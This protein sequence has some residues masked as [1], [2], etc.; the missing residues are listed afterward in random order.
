MIS[1]EYFRRKSHCTLQHRN[2]G[3]AVI[4]NQHRPVT[5]LHDQIFSEICLHLQKFS[6]LT[7][8]DIRT[9][10]Y[11]MADSTF[12]PKLERCT[13]LVSLSIPDPKWLPSLTALINLTSLTLSFNVELQFLDSLLVLH[14]LTSLKIG[15]NEPR[16]NTL[17]GSPI[18]QLTQL[19]TLS[20]IPSP[21]ISYTQLT[22]LRT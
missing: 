15:A 10:T 9:S 14:K 7:E 19:R 3:M 8:L 5:V 13:S 1:E 17:G 11:D 20:Y 2:I 6:A 4:V 21:D 22:N 16:D 12:L 18:L